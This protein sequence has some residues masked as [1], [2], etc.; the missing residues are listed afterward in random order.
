MEDKERVKTQIAHI[1]SN[2]KFYAVF[3]DTL[4]LSLPEAELFK[5]LDILLDM[6][7]MLI[8]KLETYGG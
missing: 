4:S 3:W 8:N 6:R 7:L 5:R 1:D 2:L